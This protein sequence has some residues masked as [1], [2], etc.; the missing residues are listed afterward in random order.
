[1]REA[2]TLIPDIFKVSPAI[3]YVA[4]LR[5]GKLDSAQRSDLVGASASES[6]RYEELFINPTLLTLIRQ[7]GELDCG[8]AHYVLVRYGNFYQFVHGIGI[9]HVSVCFELTANPLEFADVIQ[10]LCKISEIS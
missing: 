1:V 7:R 8:G 5:N 6:D 9:D 3:R 2:S 4:V 10:Q